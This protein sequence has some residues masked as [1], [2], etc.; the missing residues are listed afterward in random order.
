M[1]MDSET[2]QKNTVHSVRFCICL[3]S[4]PTKPHESGKVSFFDKNMKS[5][6]PT[7]F[8]KSSIDGSLW[9]IKSN[10]FQM[11]KLE[12]PFKTLFGYEKQIRPFHSIN[13]KYYEHN[14]KDKSYDDIV[15]NS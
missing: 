5:N 9:Q 2:H 4:D 11:A 12:D 14:L 3:K 10:A 15:K 7:H 8:S 6:A 1:I 13:P